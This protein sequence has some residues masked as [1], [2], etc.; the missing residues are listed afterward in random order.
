MFVNGEI[1]PNWM[2]KSEKHVTMFLLY[3]NHLWYEV[4]RWVVKS[5]VINYI[6][7]SIR[8]EIIFCP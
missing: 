7:Y 3:V 8:C 5:H 4:H 6:M 1:L 2:L